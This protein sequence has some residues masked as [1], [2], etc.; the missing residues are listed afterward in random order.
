MSYIYL[1]FDVE[2]VKFYIIECCSKILGMI[3]CVY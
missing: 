2:R 3:N 1:Y